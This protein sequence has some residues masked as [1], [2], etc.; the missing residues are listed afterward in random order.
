MS[1]LAKKEIPLLL[2]GIIGLIILL[3]YFVEFPPLQNAAGTLTNF[4]SII[5]GI[6]IGVGLVNLVIIH[7]K[8]VIDQRK[9]TWPFSLWLIISMFGTIFVGL[10]A[11]VP[12]GSAGNDIW[13][14][15]N[16]YIRSPISITIFSIFGFYVI[17]AAVHALKIK[18][19]ET[20]LFL[21]S[22]I[23]VFLWNA[24][25]GS[26]IWS[27]F[28]G[29]GAWL[30]AVPTGGAFRGVLLG[31]SLGLISMGIRI[32]TGRERGYLKLREEE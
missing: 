26:V 1:S 30:L 28:P 27:G 8:N 15:L 7:G 25:I 13:L 5:T 24:P 21:I 20:A 3:A 23:V 14:F 22:A 18:S 9:G 32:L 6:M 11:G 31:A 29:L 2:T 19:I 17:A 10:W 4:G 16:N 12:W